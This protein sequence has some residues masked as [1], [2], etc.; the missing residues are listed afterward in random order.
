MVMGGKGMRKNFRRTVRRSLGRFLA[1][2]GII[3]LGCGLF[4]GL[5]VTRSAMIATEQAYL[6]AHSMFDFRVLCTYGYEEQDVQ[7]LAALEG[8]GDAE[9]A[10]SMDVL[11]NREDAG[12]LVYKL[13]SIPSRLNTL[14]LMEGRMP[15]SPDECLADGYHVS[16]GALGSTLTVSESNETDTLDRLKTRTFTVVGLVRSPL[17]INFERGTSSLGTGQVTS[18]LYVTP[19]A[20]D[21]EVYTEVY[22]RMDRSY[23]VYS[24]AYKTALDELEPAV[25]RTAEMLAQRRLDAIRADGS[26]ALSDARRQYEDGKKEYDSQR[27]QA[28]EQLAQAA[29][30][31]EDGRIQLEENRR[32]LESSAYTLRSGQQQVQDGYSRLQQAQSALDEQRSQA[33]AQLDAADREL[34]E[35]QQQA[36]Q[37][38]LQVENG[39]DQID[40]A[41]PQIDDGLSQISSGLSQLESGL[42]LARAGL[43]AADSALS[44]AQKLLEQAEARLAQDPGNEVLIAARDTLAQ[45]VDSLQARRDALAEQAAGLESQQAELESKQAE[46]QAQ[47]ETLTAQR[48]ELQ[49][50]RQTLLDALEQ[51]DAGFDQAAQARE[52]AERQLSDAQAQ[53]DAGRAELDRS[54][55]QVSSGLSQLES[56]RAQ[57]QEAESQLESGQADYEAAK[58]EADSQL[59]QAERQL[60]DAKGQLDDAQAEL[61]ALKDPDYYVLS[62][63]TNVGYV[64]FESDSNIVNSVSRVFPFFF[65][66]VAALVCITTMTKMVDE[67]RTQIGTLKALGYGGGAILSKYLW[68]AALAS[69]AGC[70]VGIGVGTV[71]FPTILW[72]AYSI[73]Y[74][75]PERIRLVFDWP[76]SLTVVVSYAACMLGVTWW[77]CRRELAEV[78]AELIRPKAPPAG[79]RLLAERLRFWKR[80]PF[81][82]K[83]TIR[84]IFRYRQRLFMTLVGIGGCTALL[85][86]G[87]GIGDSIVGVAD[88]QFS[89]VSLY[90][91]DMSFSGNVS[92]SE[93]ERFRTRCQALGAEICFLHESSA[94][95]T[96]GGKTKSVRLL[97]PQDSLD[98]FMSL[99]RGERT[100]EMPADGRA[101]VSRG[102]AEVLGISAGDEISLQDSDMRTLTLT[103]QDIY[104]NNVYNYVITPLGSLAEQWGEAPQIQRA[105]VR[106]DSDREAHGVAAALAGETGVTNVSVNDD[107][108]QRVNTSLEGMNFIIAVIVLCAAALAFIVLYNLTNININERIREI[109]TIKVL[110]FYSGESAAYVFRE[111]LVLTLMGSV[112]G[113]GLGKLLHAFVMAQIR[114]DM[115]SFEVRVSL[116]GYLLSVALTFLF[117]CLVD[118]FL[119]FRLERINMAEAL[120]SIE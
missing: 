104:D 19:E 83:V 15:Q 82:H 79:K 38:L 111:N 93:Q 39:L 99:H 17:Y 98:G 59:S 14:E 107:L 61:D 58:T 36:M 51:I 40:A 101:L 35:K 70:A 80:V 77:S 110:G 100:L 66:L 88:Y 4:V 45:T 48:E 84:N 72:K 6:D 64:C 1:I 86:T 76:L 113:L 103:V 52:E 57:L 78:P 108:L 34:R 71:A 119:Y 116:E 41:L 2:L 3:A 37:G 43:Q 24:D 47:K 50:T 74:C 120:K 65:F 9:G 73:M 8:V 95:L 33:G 90:D 105:Y 26:S 16:A 106:L 22:L 81:L 87:F 53:I 69:L 44:A 56:G 97:A 18:F 115:I 94:D 62:R 13:H 102:V 63:N 54:A 20:F 12:D 21:L 30:A 114:I 109:A 96:A 42:R 55:A 89:Q 67:E 28:E 117:A 25:S 112:L 10:M 11:M 46:L 85:V 7:A 5:R 29:Q 23:P 49:Q 68:Y 75:M 118:F 60:R 92:A 31:L 27:A 91:M 32:R